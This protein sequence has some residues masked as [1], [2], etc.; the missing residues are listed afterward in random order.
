[1]AMGNCAENSFN[2]PDYNPRSTPEAFPLPAGKQHSV[3][4]RVLVQKADLPVCVLVLANG[5]HSFSCDGT[6]YFSLDF[7]LDENCRLNSLPLSVPNELARDPGRMALIKTAR[8]NAD[9]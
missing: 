9:I 6:G 7:P 1:V 2:C 5:S 3:S 8:L 4:G